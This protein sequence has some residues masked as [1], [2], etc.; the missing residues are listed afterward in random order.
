MIPLLGKKIVVGRAISQAARGPTIHYSN[1]R[2]FKVH[3]LYGGQWWHPRGC[4][5]PLDTRPT[6]HH[7]L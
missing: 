6:H 2:P 3:L 7:I 1:S 5:T 4:V